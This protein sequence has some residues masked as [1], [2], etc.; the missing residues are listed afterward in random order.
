[1]RYALSPV[2]KTRGRPLAGGMHSWCPWRRLRC[3]GS[4]CVTTSWP[5]TA[6]GSASCPAA[7]VTASFWST[8][9]ADPDAASAVVRL[10]GEEADTLAEL[11]GAPWVVDRIA[12]LHDQVEGLI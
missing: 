5:G 12:R 8:P 9:R 4:R 7:T 1:M 10:S 2:R 11:L 3:P 6:V